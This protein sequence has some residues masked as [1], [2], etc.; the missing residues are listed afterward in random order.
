MRSRIARSRFYFVIA[1]GTKRREAIPFLV[2]LW[3]A[4]SRSIGPRF[5]LT[6][7]LLAMMIDLTSSLVSLFPTAG[8][9]SPPRGDYLEG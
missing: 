4:S 6:R 8:H 2:P 5:A 3:I 9:P 7:W 1:S